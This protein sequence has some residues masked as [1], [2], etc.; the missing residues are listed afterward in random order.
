MV[1]VSQFLSSAWLAELGAAAAADERLREA[2]RGVT[3]TIH[4]H[5]TGSPI[6]D[7]D[8]RVEFADGGVAVLDGPGDAEVVVSESYATAAAINRG[9]MAPAEA[10]AAGRVRLGGRPGLLSR[11]RD[12]L[13]VLGD[14]FG[15]LRGRTTYAESGRAAQAGDGVQA[16]QAGD[17]VQATQAG[18]G[19]QA[20]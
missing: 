15:E 10:F 3:L 17:G 2:S 1:H 5:V 7:V 14:V 8:Y 19:V 18:D 4:H 13:S 11:H 16:T 12:T 20:T 6:G 9:D